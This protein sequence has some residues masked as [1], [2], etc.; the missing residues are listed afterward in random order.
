MQRFVYEGVDGWKDIPPDLIGLDA[1]EEEEA[2]AKLCASG[3]FPGND[4]RGFIARMKMS[5][6]PPAEGWKRR[7]DLVRSTLGPFIPVLE[8]LYKQ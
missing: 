7:R 3:I 1:L 5:V 4:L 6:R 2:F 8:E